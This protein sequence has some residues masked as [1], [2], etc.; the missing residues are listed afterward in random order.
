MLKFSDEHK[1]LES[2][3]KKNKRSLKSLVACGILLTSVGLF[4]GCKN[5]N[6]ECEIEGL[7][8]HKLVSGTG[9]SLYAPSEWTKY[10]S[11]Y[12]EERGAIYNYLYIQTDEYINLSEEEYKYYYYLLQAGLISIEENAEALT[13]LYSENLPNEYILFEYAVQNGTYVAGGGIATYNSYYWTTDPSRDNLTGNMKLC[14]QKYYGYNVTKDENGEY[15][16]IQSPPFYDYEDLLNSDYEF[17]R[18]QFFFDSDKEYSDVYNPEYVEHYFSHSKESSMEDMFTVGEQENT[19][20]I[21]Q[22]NGK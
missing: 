3:I 14:K 11:V 12:D 13:K 19:T 6:E 22:G 7:H 20:E 4:G 5:K 18:D 9:F 16:L 15:Y 1:N 10:S 17:V 21:G 2:G 8:A